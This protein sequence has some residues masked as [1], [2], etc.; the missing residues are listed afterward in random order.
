MKGVAI[1]SAGEG[2]TDAAERQKEAI[3]GICEVTLMSSVTLVMYDPF[4]Q[5]S[6]FLTWGNFSTCYRSNLDLS[7]EL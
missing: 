7:S 2:V 6:V 4:A 5:V 3:M 1:G